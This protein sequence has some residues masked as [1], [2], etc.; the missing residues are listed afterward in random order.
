MKRRRRPAAEIL[1]L[2]ASV[3]TAAISASD[4]IGRPARLVDV[5]TLFAAGTGAGASITKVVTEW[6]ARRRGRHTQP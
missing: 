3:I 5:V 2:V 1:L 6:R 4:A